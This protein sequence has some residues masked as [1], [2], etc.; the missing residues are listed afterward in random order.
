MSRKNV[1]LPHEIIPA[2]TSAATDV[3]SDVTNIQYLDNIGLQV[4]LAS[5]DLVGTLK[6]EV[7]ANY[8]RDAQGNV[9]NAG[10]WITQ[11]SQ[12]IAAGQPASTYFDLNQ[13]SAP[14]VRLVWDRDS[15]TGTIAA[16]ITGKML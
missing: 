2:G 3:T 7:S 12:A 14:W 8:Q 4:D 10:T 5:A 1:L 13:L 6:V 11:T 16:V 9:L 15:G